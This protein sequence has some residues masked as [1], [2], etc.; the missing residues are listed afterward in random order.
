MLN[1]T[2]T[3]QRVS[4]K[5][6]CICP[7]QIIL[8]DKENRFSI[9]T[10]KNKS[11]A[12]LSIPYI[13]PVLSRD[14]Q[15]VTIMNLNIYCFYRTEC[16]GYIFHSALMVTSRLV[17]TCL[18]PINPVKSLLIVRFESCVGHEMQRPRGRCHVRRIWT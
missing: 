12:S 1:Y 14:L 6:N 8:A 13:Q 17:V 15:T 18:N 11:Y 7:I 2:E 4:S 16:E 10:R 5:Y 9:F 3:F